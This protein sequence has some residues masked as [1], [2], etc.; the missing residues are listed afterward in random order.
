VRFLVQPAPPY[1]PTK[2]ATII[3]SIPAGEILEKHPEVK[4]SYGEE[5]SGVTDIL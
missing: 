3:K 1:S 2:I 4:K 5:N